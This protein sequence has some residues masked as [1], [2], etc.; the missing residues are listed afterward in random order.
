M[1]IKNIKN[2]LTIK[3][4]SNTSTYKVLVNGRIL[5]KEVFNSRKE[6]YAFAEQEKQRFLLERGE[7]SVIAEESANYSEKAK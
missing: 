7:S 1:R 3:P 5:K 2:I 4:Q 6:A